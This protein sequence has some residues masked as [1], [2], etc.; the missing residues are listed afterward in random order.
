MLPVLVSIE[1]VL[2]LAIALFLFGA[3]IGTMDVVV[4]IHAVITE[5]RVQKPIMSGFHALFSLRGFAGA[6]IVSLLLKLGATP[7]QVIIF[8]SL[9]MISHATD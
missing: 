7:L 5:K 9:L 4:N 8:I 1:T 3:D 6:G 2:P